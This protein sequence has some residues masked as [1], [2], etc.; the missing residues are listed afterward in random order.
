M[1]TSKVYVYY[2]ISYL[3]LTKG[4]TKHKN[5]SIKL[6]LIKQMLAIDNS[7]NHVISIH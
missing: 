2:G 4:V 7:L 3:F 1:P 5:K 6:R